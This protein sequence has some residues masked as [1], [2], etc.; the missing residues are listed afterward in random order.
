MTTTTGLIKVDEFVI[1][2]DAGLIHVQEKM[3]YLPIDSANF[4]I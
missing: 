3:P 2:T 4:I 1:A